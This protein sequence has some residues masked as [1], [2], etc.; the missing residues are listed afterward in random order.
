MQIGTLLRCGGI[1]ERRI[2]YYHEIGLDAL[3]IAGVL[4][5]WLAPTDDARKASD[6]F[7]ELFREYGISVPS[8]FLSYPHQDWAHPREG[9]GLVPEQSRAERMVL[10]CRQMNW[11]RQYGVHYITCHAGFVPDERNEYYERFIS[12]MKQLVRFAASNGQEFLFETGTENAAGL[13]RTIDD[14]DEPNVGV[15][16]DPAN[17]L[18][19]GTD[20][21]AN[22]VAQLKD[23]IKVVHCKDAMPAVEGA[24]RG[25]ETVLGKGAT[26]FADL[27]KSL[28]SSGFAGPLVIERELPLG[29][30]Q[31]KDIA[32]AVKFIKSIIKGA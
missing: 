32:E 15:N 20:E 8:M 5:N 11:G 10:S 18:I 16:F 13:K 6:G 22:V 31:E 14:I 4:E 12:D 29:P 28:L 21:P 25:K 9:I 1:D 23:R 27:L 30:E 19:Y 17:M 24:S 2:A 3:Q 26:Q 7:F